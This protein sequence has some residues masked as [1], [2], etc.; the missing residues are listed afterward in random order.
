MKVSIFGRHFCSESLVLA[1]SGDNLAV[2]G[3]A[4]FTAAA[5]IHLHRPL[6]SSSLLPKIII[7]LC[8]AVPL[9]L[10]TDYYS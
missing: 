2:V 6:L 1:M 9:L 10:A 7:L 5:E 8:T 3:F 4:N